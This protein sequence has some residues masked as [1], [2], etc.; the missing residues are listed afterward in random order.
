MYAMKTTRGAVAARAAPFKAVQRAIQKAEFPAVAKPVATVAVIEALTAG[1]ADAA[2]KLFDFN[3]TLPIMA[4][5]FLL[6]MVFLDKTWF[7]P[8][9]KV[10]DERDELI[11]SKLQSVSSDTGKIAEL[12]DKAEAVLKEAR[13][14][15]NR[16]V[17]EAKAS[18][19]AEQDAKLD[20]LRKQLEQDLN[21]AMSQLDSE[22]ENAASSINE[23]V[24]L[25]TEEIMA[26]VL[27]EEPEPASA[28]TPVSTRS[29]CSRGLWL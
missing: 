3:L 10:L 1:P 6:L 23:Q 5:Q 19:Q 21:S 27:P 22:R 7:T 11:R 4:G 18:T 16:A 24:D 25:L 9:G 2:G 15:A 20:A 29:R 14:E 12:Q 8:V 13:D 17:S 26:R 28:Q